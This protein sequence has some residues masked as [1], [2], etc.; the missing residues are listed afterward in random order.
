MI[1]PWYQRIE[2]QIERVIV[3]KAEVIRQALAALLAGGHLLLEDV[4]GTGKTTLAA[5]LLR[6]ASEEG[7]AVGLSLGDK[8]IP[9]GFGAIHEQRLLAEQGRARPQQ[10]PTP[11]HD[12]EPGTNLILVTMLASAKV[13]E[14]ALRARARTSQVHLVALPEGF[15]LWPGEK[16]RR[17]FGMTDGVQQLLRKRNHLVSE[18]VQVHILRG[19]QSVLGLGHQP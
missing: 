6:A 8:A 1:A 15:F 17:V 10:N 9:V 14:G 19:N 16:G 11:V 7:I 18:G 4:P 12:P 3:G 13:L 5:S 2:R